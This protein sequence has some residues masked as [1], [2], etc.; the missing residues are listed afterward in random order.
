MVCLLYFIFNLGFRISVFN[1]EQKT[2]NIAEAHHSLLKL[3]IHPSDGWTKAFYKYIDAVFKKVQ[4]HVSN[5]LSNTTTG[6][7]IRNTN[8]FPV[9][10]V[11]VINSHKLLLKIL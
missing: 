2:N 4:N 10:L 11:I 1:L 5:I 3:A 9:Y 6:N 8:I 7:L